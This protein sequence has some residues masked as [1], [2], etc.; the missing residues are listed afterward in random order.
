MRILA[1]YLGIR[2]PFQVAGSMFKPT[3]R[4][5]SGQQVGQRRVS[6]FLRCYIADDQSRLAKSHPLYVSSKSSTCKT[7]EDSNPGL[8]DTGRPAQ[9]QLLS[10]GL[11]MLAYNFDYLLRALDPE[12][13]LD[14]SVVGDDILRLVM[15]L[16]NCP[17]LGSVDH[18]TSRARA[19]PLDAAVLRYPFAKFAQD[20][21]RQQEESEGRARR[22]TYIVVD[23]ESQGDIDPFVLDK[24]I[25]EEEGWDLL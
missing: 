19:G 14:A 12:N 15:H 20:L 13:S 5:I 8:A 18:V 11:Q 4:A 17:A 9:A 16:V 24:P 7:K 22:G 25:K 21:E 2:L 10:F 3:I 6:I 23:D 1:F